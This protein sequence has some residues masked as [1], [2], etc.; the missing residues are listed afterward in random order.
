MQTARDVAVAVV[1]EANLDGALLLAHR[2]VNERY[3]EYCLTAKGRHLRRHG[4]IVVPALIET[5]TVTATR[6]SAT[7]TGNAAAVLAWGQKVV[8][9]HLKVRTVWYRI[10]GLDGND[11][12][13]SSTFEEASATAVAYTIAPR[14][15]PLPPDA[16]WLVSVTHPRLDN[17]LEVLNLRDLEILATSR[18][19]S[20][21][22]PIYYAE[23]EPAPGGLRQIEVYPFPENAEKLEIIYYIVPRDLGLRDGIPF[24]IEASSLK[25]GA[26]VNAYGWKAMRA[27][28]FEMIATFGNLQ[29]R[30]RSIWKEEKELMARAD[31]ATSSS[32]VVFQ[33][34]KNFKRR[35]LRGRREWGEW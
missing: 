13:L 15:I 19:L 26:L 8:G 5:G 4:E 12:H 21:T 35:T 18:P 1:T 23:T 34:T 20:D 17:P 31:K 14:R 24:G 33:N 10:I 27:E 6:G 2:W 32:T 29:A 22:S 11:L 28:N 30:Q 7:V 16:R 9:R 3:R 25:E